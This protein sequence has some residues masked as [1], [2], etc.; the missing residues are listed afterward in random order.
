MEVCRKNFCTHAVIVASVFKHSC[1]TLI[2]LDIDELWSVICFCEKGHCI[3]RLII[4]LPCKI[5]ELDWTL[6]R[7][8]FCALWME[9]GSREVN[10]ELNT[11][12]VMM[13]CKRWTSISANF[14]NASVK[15]K[16]YRYYVFFYLNLMNTNIWIFEDFNYIEKTI[17]MF[18]WIFLFVEGGWIHCLACSSLSYPSTYVFLYLILFLL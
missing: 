14:R 7:Y 1:I 9:I 18:S 12:Y 11:T 17:C 8:F 5:L 2:S 6:T 3:V 10:D 15:N 16:K 4:V 13:L